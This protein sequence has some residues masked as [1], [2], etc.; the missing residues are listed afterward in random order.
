VA[1]LGRPVTEARKELNEIAAQVVPERVREIPPAEIKPGCR[2]GWPDFLRFVRTLEETIAAED[3]PLVERLRRA[4]FWVRLAGEAHFDKVQGER[5][6]EFLELISQAAGGEV[7]EAPEVTRP[8][9]AGFL[10]F[11]T[12]AGFY[13]RKDTAVEAA[14]GWRVRW[15]RLRAAVRFAR[16]TGNVPVLQSGFEEVPF[17]ALEE[18]LGGWPDE[19]EEIL[20][21]Y[22]RV[23]IRGLHF[24]G[25]AYYNVPFVE[26]FW[27]LALVV[28]VVAYLARWHALSHGRTA[29]TTEDVSRALA[30]ADHQHGYAPPLGSR[31]F[32]RR[33]RLLAAANDVER[34]IVHYA[35]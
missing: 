35:E 6:G 28:P 27:S 21:R 32:R 5:L 3:A 23:K 26:G 15:Q 17:A 20:T 4:L 24:C 11:R 1:N 34:L 33:V 2:L 22:L 29:L 25:P 31:G 19:A 30:I 8:T 18:P 13:A 12:L 16:G 14:G 9:R 7:A 10:Q